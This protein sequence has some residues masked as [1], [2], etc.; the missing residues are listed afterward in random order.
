MISISADPIFFEM[1]DQHNQTKKNNKIYF[2][3]L[4]IK[5]RSNI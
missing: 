2:L 4:K 3:C 5:C 1:L